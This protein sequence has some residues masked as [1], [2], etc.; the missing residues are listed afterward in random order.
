MRF[1]YILKES[2]TNQIRYVGQTDNPNRRFNDHIKTSFN[3]KSKHYNL[4]KSNWIRKTI[5]SGHEIIMYIIEICEN[6]ENSNIREKYWI[7]K[8]TENGNLLTNS[9]VI[10]VTE[11]S[12][13]TRQKMSSA[14]KGKKLEE[15]VGEEKSIELKEYYSERTRINNPNKCF[16]SNVRKK[17]S[18]T[19]KK[20][21][22]NP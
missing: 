7:D 5:N 1:I 11:F 15:I 2:N 21:F 3:K 13:E 19:L 18:D 8:L 14:K 9:H 6:L 22:S 17:I 4:H 10:D 20:Y 12:V 16:D